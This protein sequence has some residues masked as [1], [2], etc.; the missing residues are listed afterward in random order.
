MRLA[1]RLKNGFQRAPWGVLAARGVFLKVLIFQ[2][3]FLSSRSFAAEGQS[4]SAEAMSSLPDYPLGISRVERS[5]DGQVRVMWP[6]RSSADESEVGGLP[7]QLQLGADF[8]VVRCLPPGRWVV[9]GQGEVAARNGDLVEGLLSLAGRNVPLDKGVRD[10]LVTAGNLF[11]AP[12]VG[13]LV[14][15]RRKEILQRNAI[16]PR[17]TLPV[18]S[19]FSA[20]SQSE[21]VE[22]TRQGR[23]S[24]RDII[25]NS[26][27]DARGRLLIEVHARRQGSRSQLR[28]ETT[29]KAKNIEQFLRYEFSLAREQIVSVGMGSDT[30]VPGLVPVGASTD[31]VVLRMIP[32]RT[33]SL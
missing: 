21:S 16:T 29:L 17:V 4:C 28:D 1:E 11:P 13:D 18:D 25:L 22:L 6:L 30:Y 7:N 8:D 24:L 15:I 14:V 19:L 23:Q 26:F 20:T 9:L 2:A 10:E 33:A 31:V 12:M 32:G 27:A 5:D 3:L